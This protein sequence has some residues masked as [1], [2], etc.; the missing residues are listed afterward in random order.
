MANRTFKVYGQA[1]AAS[2]DVSVVMTVGGTEVFNGAVNDSSTVRDGQPTVENHLWTYTMDEN[3]TGDLAVSIA[4]TG[5]E[6]CLGPTHDNLHYTQIIPESWIAENSATIESAENQTYMATQIGQTLLDAEQAGLYDKLVAGTASN[7]ADGED[8]K[9]ANAKGPRSADTFV[10]IN[11]V[12]TNL[13]VTGTPDAP[14]ISEA[15]TSKE[16][17]DWWPVLQDGDTLTYTWTYDPDADA[18]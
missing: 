8:I 5:G 2:G 10:P 16:K 6:L 3:T 4:V 14:Q 1:Y 9:R 7:D 13:A 15:T 11:D 17:A 18:F 12:R